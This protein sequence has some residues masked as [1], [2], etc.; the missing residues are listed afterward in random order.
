LDRPVS[1]EVKRELIKALVAGILVETT[2]IDR[3][4]QSKITVAYRF[5]E[6]GESAQLVLPQA[7]SVGGVVRLPARPETIGDHICTVRIK[8][9]LLQREVANTLGVEKSSVYNWESNQ[10]E[11][12]LQYM[13]P[14]LQFSRLQPA[15]VGHDRLGR[16]WCGAE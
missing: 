14:T 2:E 9:K 1:W 6:P 5:S 12:E 13:P 16:A 11:P 4:K 8:R 15:A 10:S 7:Y 3:A